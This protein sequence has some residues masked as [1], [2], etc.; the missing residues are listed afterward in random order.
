MAQS[1]DSPGTPDRWLVLLLAALSYFTLY[2]HRNLVNYLQPPIKE[3]FDVSDEQI[4]FLSTAFLLPY[5]LVQIGVGYLS[6]RLSRRLVLLLCLVSSALVLAL[7]GLTTVY[8]EYL[9]L[10]FVLAFAQSASVPAIASLIADSFT[11]RS[12]STAIGIYLASYN[13]SLVVAGR[14][15]GMLADEPEW[16]IPLGWLGLP[17]L[18]LAGWRSAHLLFALVGGFVAL[19]VLAFLREPVRTERDPH[20]ERLSLRQT[21]AAT[22]RVPTFWSLGV[23]FG[24]QVGVVTMMQYWLP[25]YLY[26]RFGLTLQEA[27]FQGTIWIQSATLAGLFGGGWLADRLA[28]RLIPGRTLVQFAGLTLAATA[29]LCLAAAP[30]LN[31]LVGPMILFGVGTGMY[32]A[33]LW[34]GT[35]EVVP[36]TARATAIG[37]LNVASGAISSWWSPVIGLYRDRGGDLGWALAFLGLPMI[38]AALLLLVNVLFLLRRD[39]LGPLPKEAP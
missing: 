20:A 7:S 5:T 27:G 8:G 36:A 1:S 10:R 33:S 3:A 22:L 4:G 23:I 11:P 16:T 25:R 32:Q 28:R 17:P 26:V 31:V 21:L 12:R 14:Y 24:L 19:L 34:A 2:L 39:Y 18:T 35:F 13:L 29:L 6:D 30:A 37:L 15:G 9:A 38:Q